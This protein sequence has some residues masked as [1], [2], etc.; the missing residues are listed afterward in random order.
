MA[1]AAAATIEPSSMVFGCSAMVDTLPYGSALL[2]ESLAF[3]GD[4]KDPR[5]MA[6]K[7]A[8]M[9]HPKDTLPPWRDSFGLFQRCKDIVL[10][11]GSTTPFVPDGPSTLS[12]PILWNPPDIG[13]TLV[14]LFGG[15]GTELAAVLEA[16]LTV[17]RYVYVYNFPV[18]TR[19]TRHHLHQL[20]VLYPD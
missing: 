4:V 15:I 3:M 11:L 13:I 16:G 6:L 14:E 19:V 7:R 20:M 12:R 10:S 2:E 9:H 8:L 1:F 5:E 17:K 18:S